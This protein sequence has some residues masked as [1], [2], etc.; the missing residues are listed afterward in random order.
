MAGRTQ[1]LGRGG[2]FISLL[3]LLL[4][5]GPLA[6]T[7][8][9]AR[10]PS[11]H[12]RDVLGDAAIFGAL[13][14]YGYLASTTSVRVCGSDLVLVRLVAVTTVPLLEVSA[15]SGENGL[16]VRTRGGQT[17]THIGYGSSL[18]GAMTG[19]RRSSRVAARIQR[20]VEV[21]GASPGGVRGTTRRPRLALSLFVILP[22]AYSLLG[23][24]IHG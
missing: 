4:I 20:A 18:L 16:E 5:V 19:N 2:Q 7:V 6:L 10:G 11:D 3:G 13:A 17:L 14:T 12:L 9:T 1:V 23:A 22:V 21:E 15:V 8:L 24:G